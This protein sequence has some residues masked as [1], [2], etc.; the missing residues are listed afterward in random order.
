MVRG[1]VRVPRMASGADTKKHGCGHDK[2]KALKQLKKVLN[3]LTT[4]TK[5]YKQI[6]KRHKRLRTVTKSYSLFIRH[7]AKVM[8]PQISIES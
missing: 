8:Y 7:L 3:N 5:D 2:G 1:A 6:K 4:V